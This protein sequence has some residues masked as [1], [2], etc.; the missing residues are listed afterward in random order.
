VYEGPP[1]GT[2]RVRLGPEE[3]LVDFN[4]PYRIKALFCNSTF[5]A[6]QFKVPKTHSDGST[7][8]LKVWTNVRRDNDWWAEVI[9]ASIGMSSL[10][11][12]TLPLDNPEVPDEGGS[13]N[14]IVL[15]KAHPSRRDAQTPKTSAPR[16]LWDSEAEEAN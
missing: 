1:D 5:S 10:L 9:D 14:L 3:V 13:N 7:S 16:P 12:R 6:V 2:P 4:K 15:T 11:A 8:N